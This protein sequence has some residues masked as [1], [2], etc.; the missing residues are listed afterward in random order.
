MLA[1]V[2]MIGVLLHVLMDFPTTYGTRLLSPF[3]WHWFGADWVPIVDIYLLMMLA[4][5]L[6]FGRTSPAAR[7]R[8]AAIVLTLMAAN[9]GVRA[10]AHHRAL[11]LVPQLFGPTLPPPC[12]TPAPNL[13]LI[14]EW[15]IPAASAAA[16]P[17]G[18]RCLVEAAAMP[19]FISPFQWRII[20][21]VS[22]AYEVRDVNLLDD[23]LP[24][25]RR[26]NRGAL[27]SDGALPERVDAR[28][29]ARGSDAGGA[30]LPGIL[31]VSRGALG[32]RPARCHHRAI[33]RHAVCGSS[34]SGSIRRPTAR[35]PLP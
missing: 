18:R 23:G 12:Q 2:A 3:D 15:P 35:I 31:A 24:Q 6:W 5:G 10:T 7:R 26:R 19:S 4:A 8:N 29:G 34:A 28:R 11:A 27:A 32:R 30:G 17:T 1:A 22:N 14:D 25:R 20:L 13:G 9:Y 16:P 21:H 33:H